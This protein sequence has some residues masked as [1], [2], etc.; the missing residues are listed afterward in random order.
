MACAGVWSRVTSAAGPT[1]RMRASLTAMAPSWITDSG[2][3]IGSTR[4]A[5]SR[6]SAGVAIGCRSLVVPRGSVVANGLVVGA[7]LVVRVVVAGVEVV[8]LEPGDHL[9]R[10]DPCGE[11]PVRRPDVGAQ[12]AHGV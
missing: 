3:V 2:P 4:A 1:A 11:R 7:R 6:R 5:R 9:D 8:R 10:G 12:I